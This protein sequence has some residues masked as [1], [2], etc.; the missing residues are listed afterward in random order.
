MLEWRG[1]QLAFRDAVRRFIDGEIRPAID[2]FE[3]EA[4]PPYEV[5]RKLLATFGIAELQRARFEARIARDEASARGQTP[6]KAERPEGPSDAA[7]DMAAFAM[8]PTIELA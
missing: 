1:Q 7:G 8:L 6:A 2:E 4:V 3:H 5:L